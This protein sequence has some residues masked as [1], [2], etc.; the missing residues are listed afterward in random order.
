MKLKVPS[1]HLGIDG[2]IDQPRCYMKPE[3]VLWLDEK[4]TKFSV[5]YWLLVDPFTFLPA[6]TAWIELEDETVALEYKLRWL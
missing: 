1:R 2:D 5:V 4:C 3:L 6:P